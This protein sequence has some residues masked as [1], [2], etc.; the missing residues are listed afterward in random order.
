M[1]KKLSLSDRISFFALLATVF[2]LPIFFLPYFQF[3]LAVSKGVLFSFGITISLFF[4]L[5][6]RLLDG[7]IAI[8]KNGLIWGMLAIVFAAFVSAI[9]SDSVKLSLWG[10]AY[11]IDTFFSILLLFF[12]FFLAANYFQNRQAQLWL[13]GGIFVSY[14]A[15]II[16][17]VLNFFVNFGKLAPNFFAGLSTSNLVGSLND[18]AIFSGVIVIAGIFAIEN[19]ELKKGVKIF[20]SLVAF[21]GLFALSLSDYTAVWIVVGI[22]ALLFMVAGI[23]KRRA[24]IKEEGDEV[25]ARRWP[26]IPTIVLLVSIFFVVSGPSFVARLLGVSNLDVRPSPTATWMIAS[27]ALSESPIVGEG[28]GRFVNAWLKWKPAAVNQDVFF[29]DTNF[30]FGF[31]FIPSMLVTVG[32]LGGLSIIFFLFFLVRQIMLAFKNDLRDQFGRFL[33]LSLATLTSFLWLF[34]IIYTPNLVILMLAFVMTG[35][36]VGASILNKRTKV[37]SLQFLKDPRV[38]FFFILGLVVLMGGTAFLGYKFV[39]KFS[40]VVYYQKA[41]L[42][43]QSPE[44]MDEAESKLVRAITLNENDLYYRSLSEL[45]LLKLSSLLQKQQADP[46]ADLEGSLQETLGLAEAAAKGAIA[47]DQSNYLNHLSLAT[48]Y[49]SL[50]PLGVPN[51]YESAKMALSGAQALNP[52]SPAIIL[53]TAR[54]EAGNGDSAAARDEANK[55][56]ALKPNYADAYVFLAQLDFKENDQAGA[57]LNLQKALSLDPQNQNLKDA[58]NSLQNQAPPPANGPENTPI[59]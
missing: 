27:K 50:L 55:A 43:A 49:E 58:L 10:G 39:K 40:S 8:P 37:Y 1:L 4:Y 47:F 31:G 56:L 16:F 36:L 20:L 45:Y 53:R 59:N 44:K 14:A 7:K 11:E 48:L 9:F 35:A 57:T 21:L 30:N 18:L 2:L 38:S 51:S 54:L 28:P 42:V 13:F 24:K 41:V 34:A 12:S 26:I 23:S 52:A 22:I 25:V 15:S 6:A 3:S 33:S 32:L 29:W 17:I 5:L 46:S 19:L